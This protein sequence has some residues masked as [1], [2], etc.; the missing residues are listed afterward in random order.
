MA[1]GN[2]VTAGGRIDPYGF[3]DLDI[4]GL[5]QRRGVKWH[6]PG[7]DLL[8]AWVADMDFAPPPPVARALQA[9]VERGD[10]GYPAWLDSAPPLAGAFAHRMHAHHGWRPRPDRVHMFTDLLQIV[11]VILHL[12]TRPGDGVAIHLPNYPPFL[13]TIASMDR[14]LVPIVF[15]RGPGGWRFDAA[16]FAHDVAARGC[17]VLMLINPH[18]PTGRVLTRDELRALG[19]IAVDHDLL[20]IADE[21][22]A[23]LVYEPHVHVPFASLG[24]EVADRTVTAT[25]ATKAFNIAGVRCAVAHVGETT[26]HEQLCSLPPDLFG[27]VGA[28]GVEATLAAWN[29]GDEWLAA[30]RRKLTRNRDLLADLLSDRLPRIVFEPPEATYLAWL[31]CRR[32]DLSAEPAEFWRANAGVELSPGLTFGPQGAGFARLNFATS[33]EIL[34]EIVERMAA[35]VG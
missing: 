30:L 35:A 23:D 3:D 19:Q 16:R 4:A 14:R 24:S 29:D 21:I 13:E 33:S 9:M 10:L 6:R 20:V 17:R 12:Q 28:P 31:D 26:L 34:T 27:T 15:E 5:R 11:Q 32:L 1:A 2:H 25:S 8:P 7:P 18:N 22:H